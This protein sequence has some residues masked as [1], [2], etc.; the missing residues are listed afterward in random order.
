MQ[1]AQG[2][3]ELLI[4]AFSN[5]DAV[6]HRCIELQGKVVVLC[7]GRN[8]KINIEDLLFAGALAQ[9]LSAKTEV[10]FNSDAVNIAIELWNEAKNDLTEYIKKTEH[11]HRLIANGL[12]EDA[13]FCLQLNTAPLVPKYNSDGKIRIN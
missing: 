4:G 13:K 12:E 2:C 7:A 3:R 5:I 11:Y 9:K 1:V 8:N 10:V 6:V